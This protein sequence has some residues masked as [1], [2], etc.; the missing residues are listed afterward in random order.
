MPENRP[1]IPVAMQRSVKEEA[2]YR[3]AIPTCGQTASLELCHI[4]P[5][6][7]VR[8]H[9]FDNLICLCSICHYRFD[10]GQIPK[11]S[12]LN[13]KH[14]LGLLT[15]RYSQV[16]NQ[17]LNDFAKNGINRSPLQI[18]SG[19]RFMLTNLLLDGMLTT[20]DMGANIY[21]NGVP[22]NVAIALTPKG[23]DLV[24]KMAAADTV[25]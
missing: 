10:Q 16:E 4:I 1:A 5:W 21:V 23:G 8:E 19:M 25:E 11:Q 12:I 7:K 9:T 14:N 24:R 3:C 22:S 2:G 15:H 13:F 18:H 17:L 6:S 20:V